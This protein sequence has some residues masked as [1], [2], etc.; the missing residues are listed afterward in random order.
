MTKPWSYT[1]T[2][3]L[4]I[5]GLAHVDL[6]DAP[7]NALQRHGHQYGKAKDATI[8]TVADTRRV[9]EYAAFSRITGSNVKTQQSALTIAHTETDRYGYVRTTIATNGNHTPQGTMTPP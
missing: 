4:N 5:D 3:L 2:P 9:A 7:I 8:K 1:K 6:E